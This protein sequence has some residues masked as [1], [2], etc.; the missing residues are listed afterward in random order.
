ML[1]ARPRFQYIVLRTAKRQQAQP[2]NEHRRQQQAFSLQ[3]E[4]RPKATHQKKSADEKG[5]YIPN[6]SQSQPRNFPQKSAKSTTDFVSQKSV[7]QKLSLPQN[8]VE[9]S[10]FGLSQNSAEVQP[11]AEIC[12]TLCRNLHRVRVRRNLT[13]R[14]TAR[15]KGGSVLPKTG[16]NLN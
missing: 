3:A 9:P 8:S 14:R 16:I 6:E 10:N 12:Q 2:E 15:N 1:D 13:T 11:L 4:N 5:G 7:E